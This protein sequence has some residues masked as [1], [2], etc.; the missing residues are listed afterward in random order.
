MAELNGFE[1]D[2][3]VVGSGAGGGM[4]A[5][6]LT[7]EGLRVLM[8]EAGRDY[9]PIEETPMF[10]TNAEAPLRGTSNK[11]KNFGYYD[12]TVDGGWQVPGE[13]YTMAEGTKFMLWRARMLG[14][15]T[16]HWGR[17]VPRFGPYDFKPKTRDG[18]GEDWPIDYDEIEPWYDKTDHL[19]G[20]CGDNPGVDNIPDVTEGVMQPAPE[21]RVM[22]ILLKK[23]CE[24]LDIPVVKMRRAVM[25]EDKGDGRSPCFWATNCG[26]GCS[27]GA[28]FQT[29]TSLIPFAKATGRLK[30]VTDAMVKWVHTGE[31]GQANA[32]TYVDRQTGKD[33]KLKA[34]RVVL[35]P[36]ATETARIL[37]NSK[38]KKY[39]NGLANSSG[40]V[41]R[42]LM[43][44]TGAGVSGH[45]PA[46]QGRPRY[47]EDG[48]TGN[49]YY[50]P[51]WG[52]QDQAKGK[53][54]F[55]RG[56][57][58]EFGGRFSEPNIWTGGG[59]DGYGKKAK[60][61]VRDK[62]GSSIGFSLRGEM[63]PNENCY[64]EIDSEVKDKWGIP[65]LKFHWK[66]A[67]SE[68]KQVEHGLKWGEKIIKAMGG[69]VT[70][71]K[72][73]GE[74]AIL[75]GGQIIHEV[76]TTRMGDDPKTSVTNKHG[77]TWD[78]D[79]LFVM[80]GGVFVS[81]PHQNCTITIMALAMKNATWMS[82]Q[83]KRGVL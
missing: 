61:A 55:P 23:A 31:A 49:H 34:P 28:A 8:L 27:I 51:W 6:T 83:I 35:A 19:I 66:W 67:E 71:P 54:N 53:L 43:D 59:V 18:Y 9:D 17:L 5:Y 81:S 40:Q 21:P 65:V 74:E 68:I 4:A 29:T 62:Y 12:A 76:G 20:V 14:G 75:A 52:Y 73:T 2:V 37:L 1:Y 26:R 60:Q 7:K 47:N 70:S 41:G 10:Q 11:D 46:M 33:V 16:N 58:F 25:T 72:R 45:V 50:V 39:P 42:N 24:S 69:V 64:C 80:D 82:K 63:V 36:S 56:Y 78:V 30:V 79:N 22:E 57:H 15:R 48:H 38:S 3:V 77:Q 32:V 13:P 44:S